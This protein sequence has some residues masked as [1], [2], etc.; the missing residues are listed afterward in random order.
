M[1]YAHNGVQ[2]SAQ[3]DTKLKDDDLEKAM[4]AYHQLEGVIGRLFTIHQKTRESGRGADPD[5]KCFNNITFSL[6]PFL[7]M[8]RIAFDVCQFLRPGTRP[9]FLDAGCGLGT[10]AFLARHSGFDGYG[11]DINPVYAEIATGVIDGCGNNNPTYKDSVEVCNILEY[12]KY[13]EFD[14]IYWYTPMWD[15]DMMC[16][17]QN[18]ILAQITRPTVIM[19]A[20]K[21]FFSNDGTRVVELQ[22]GCGVHLAGN[23]DDIRK[24]AKEWHEHYK[25]RNSPHEQQAVQA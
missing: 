11:I 3:K 23:S 14:C 22:G 5:S 16:A 9:K 19:P 15:N 7:E 10:K 24:I 1:F 4:L 2:V 21:H 12:Q 25:K 6:K 20:I 8:L 17:F 18:R 13:G